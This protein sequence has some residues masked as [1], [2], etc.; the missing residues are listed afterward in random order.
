MAAEAPDPGPCETCQCLSEEG[1]LIFAPGKQGTLAPEWKKRLPHCTSATTGQDHFFTSF[2]PNVVDKYSREIT[3]PSQR[4]ICLAQW[5]AL[6]DPIRELDTYKRQCTTDGWAPLTG[7]GQR[8]TRRCE[9][10][11][12]GSWAALSHKDTSNRDMSCPQT[13]AMAMS[14][15]LLIRLDNNDFMRNENILDRLKQI[16]ERDRGVA[17]QAW[18]IFQHADQDRDLQRQALP[19]FKELL[20]EGLVAPKDVAWLADRNMIADENHQLYGSHTRCDGTRAVFEP[21]LDDPSLADRRRAEIGM[22][23]A[24]ELLDQRS[25]QRCAGG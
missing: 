11:E 21:P 1:H 2:F 17:D 4:E 9:E 22:P 5:L 7:I 10:D 15:G 14:M 20:K 16:L 18:L 25:R 19:R 12:A 6:I 13:P 23:P 24:R 8:I 3:D